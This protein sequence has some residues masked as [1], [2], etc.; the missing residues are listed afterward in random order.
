MNQPE[1]SPRPEDAI[2]DVALGLPPGERAAYVGKACGDDHRLRELVTALLNAHK[3]SAL[4]LTENWNPIVAQTEPLAQPVVPSEKIGDVIGRYQ[5]LEQLGEGGSGIVYLAVQEEPVRRMVALKILKLGMDTRQIIARFEAE[6]QT[7]ALMEHPNIARVFDAGA[8]DTGRPYFVMELVRGTRIT[9]YCDQHHLDTRQRLELFIQV[10][11]A[12]QHAHQKGIIHRDIKPSNVLVTVEDQRPVPKVIDFG[13]AK[14]TGQELSPHTFYT[15][16]GQI[17]GT[18]AYMSPE[19]AELGAVDID[20]R[21]D[22]YSLGVLLYELLTG[23]APT[24]AGDWK[25]MSLDQITRIIREKEAPKPST[26][27]R[28]LD[29]AEQSLL[30]RRR[31]AEPQKLVSQLRGDLDWIVMK[32]LDKDRARRYPTVNGLARDVERH[33]KYEP[34][35]ARPPL[36]LYRLRKFV[37]RNKLKFVAASAVGLAIFVSAILSG[38]VFIKDLQGKR[39]RQRAQTSNAFLREILQAAGP[40]VAL[41]RDT[42]LL[43]EILNLSA[44]RVIDR[45]R[46]QP[47]IAAEHLQMIAEV[48]NEWGRFTNAL[49]MSQETLRLRKAAFGTRSVPVADTMAR[50]GVILYNLGEVPGAAQMDRESLDL[51]IALLGNEH[52]NV[53]TSYNNLG[54]ALWTLGKLSEA[55]EA[56]IKG[57]KI[58][59]KALGPHSQAVGQSLANLG[60]ILSVQGDMAGAEPLLIE[61][62]DIFRS[63]LSPDHPTLALLRNNLGMI[64]L[65]KGDFEGSKTNFDEALRIRRKV[66][67]PKHPDIAYSLTQLATHCS[68]CGHLQE[69]LGLLNEAIEMQDSDSLGGESESP[70]ALYCLGWVLAKTGDFGAAEHALWR[71]LAFRIAALGEESPDVAEVLDALAVVR[72]VRGDPGLAASLLERA[73]RMDNKIQGPNHPNLASWEVHLAWILNQAGDHE[74]A[75]LES[76]RAMTLATTNGAYGLRAWTQANYDLAEVLQAMARFSDAEALLRESAAVVDSTAPPN[77]SFQSDCQ[78]RLG[79]CYESWQVVNPIPG[80]KEMVGHPPN[81]RGSDTPSAGR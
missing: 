6:R 51:R 32:C 17:L 4:A 77:T 64:L 27:L 72:A 52:T 14:A 12:I 60:S 45:F 63:K 34:V 15:S 40:S 16:P 69:A 79:R 46:D 19:Q 67:G 65:R 39:D 42:T 1:E 2:L 18:P 62:L 80:R 24:D 31:L 25:G 28:Q 29:A 53:A 5:L 61:A 41:G 73:I 78:A 3:Q 44:A 48:Y 36:N 9:D 74:R 49:D 59:R 75:D 33:L 70:D 21:S 10:C 55:K 23:K 58:R 8:T 20:T 66:L 43:M 38:W 7:L 26:R 11:Q 56:E 30:S 54:V 71:A 76:K 68:S 35:T 50:I 81:K 22:I 57:L 37:R 13:I 47:D